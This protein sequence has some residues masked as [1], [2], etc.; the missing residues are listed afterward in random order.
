MEDFDLM[1][2]FEDLSKPSKPFI[3][4]SIIELEPETDHPRSNQNA[5]RT[6]SGLDFS[7]DEKQKLNYALE[8]VSRRLRRKFS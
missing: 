4:P 2:W 3:L 1:D 6:Q 5:E 7:V 8:K